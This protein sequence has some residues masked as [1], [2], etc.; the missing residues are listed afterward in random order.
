M[1]THTIDPNEP[2][3]I[4]VYHAAH[5]AEYARALLEAEEIACM[6]LGNTFSELNGAIRLAVRRDQA[7]EALAALDAPTEEINE[8]DDDAVPR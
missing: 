1:R 8:D 2:V 6:L 7:A 4:R 5:E 3:V